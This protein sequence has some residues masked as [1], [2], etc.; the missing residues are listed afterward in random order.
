VEYSAVIQV[1]V[2]IYFNDLKVKSKV[3]K[4]VTTLVIYWSVHVEISLVTIGPSGVSD[5]VCM[6]I[7]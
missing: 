3:M 5:A 1:V 2:C 7:Q 6:Y 4:Y